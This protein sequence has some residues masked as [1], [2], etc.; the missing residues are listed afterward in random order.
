MTKLNA[1]TVTGV[2][3]ALFVT[4][5]LAISG[6]FAGTSGDLSACDANTR[7]KVYEWARQHPG[8]DRVA[9]CKR[10]SL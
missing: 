3:A 10:M 1:L 7:G 2:A 4:A 9:E 5:T 8:V 6:S